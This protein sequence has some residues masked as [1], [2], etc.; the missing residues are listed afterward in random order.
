MTKKKI[1]ILFLLWILLLWGVRIVKVNQES[2]VSEISFHMQETFDWMGVK[3]TPMEAHM[4]SLEEYNDIMGAEASTEGND[5]NILCLK[6]N[7]VNETG[8]D[9]SWDALFDN[10]GYG[11]ETITW[12]SA[13][14]PYLGAEINI[15]YSEMFRDGTSQD[16][17]LATTVEKD[18]FKKRHWDGVSEMEYYYIM[19]VYPEPVKI[20]LEF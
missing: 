6:L 18:C 17:W 5:D 10:F 14:Q 1:G 15:F 12:C 4:Y 19:S 7:V 9:I 20:K 2:K 16:I 3:V 8:E 11:F 13:I